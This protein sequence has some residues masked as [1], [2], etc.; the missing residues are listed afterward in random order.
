MR[1]APL[2]KNP[3]KPFR[4]LLDAR[5]RW[6][7]SVAQPKG[8]LGPPKAE[9][10]SSNLAGC[11]N[12]FNGLEIISKIFENVFVNFLPVGYLCTTHATDKS[13]NSA[14]NK[15]PAKRSAAGQIR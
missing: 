10:A 12:L 14:L 5:S 13:T 6:F 2:E 8:S 15:A 9:A 11:A 4:P 3:A 7:S 1:W